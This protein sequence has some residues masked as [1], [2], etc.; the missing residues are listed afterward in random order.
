MTK[1]KRPKMA[2]VRPEEQAYLKRW[3]GAKSAES[4]WERID[5]DP[6]Y[7]QAAKLRNTDMGESLGTAWGRGKV[8]K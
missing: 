7:E 5:R 8:P 1:N 6:V 4:V 2:P 3:Q